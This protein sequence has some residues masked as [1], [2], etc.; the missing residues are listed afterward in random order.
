MTK[1]KGGREGG[2]GLCVEGRQTQV[3]VYWKFK[4]TWSL[5]SDNYK[6]QHNDNL[7]RNRTTSRSLHQLC[8]KTANAHEVTL[9]SKHLVSCLTVIVL[10]SVIIAQQDQVI[11]IYTTRPIYCDIQ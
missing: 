7:T 5:L 6:T 3:H 4:I 10:L 2:R 11:V 8:T 1:N 9:V